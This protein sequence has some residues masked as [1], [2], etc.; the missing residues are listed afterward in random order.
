M[1]DRQPSETA[2]Q[3]IRIYEERIRPLLQEENFGRVI[4]IDAESGDYEIATD[5]DDRWP[6]LDRLRRRHPEPR[7][8]TMRIGGGTV[9]KIGGFRKVRQEPS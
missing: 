4:S 8:F 7:V 5:R 6:S 1:A 3:A 2:E 9:A